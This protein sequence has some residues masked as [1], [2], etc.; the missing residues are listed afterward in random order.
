MRRWRLNKSWNN[1]EF[2]SIKL[3]TDIW[4]YINMQHDITRLSFSPSSPHLEYYLRQ[5][6]E[7]IVKMFEEGDSSHD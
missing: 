3:M 4:F 2:E 6:N 7:K 1:E 5:D